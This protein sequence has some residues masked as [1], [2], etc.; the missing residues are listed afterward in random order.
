MTLS[1]DEKRLRAMF[2]RASADFIKANNPVGA[3]RVS[4]AVVKRDAPQALDGG[5]SA[6]GNGKAR[7]RVRITRFACRLLDE[8][9]LSGGVKPLLDSIKQA[10]LIE[11]DSP[12]C[13]ELC[14]RQEKVTNKVHERTEVEIEWDE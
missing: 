14:V 13:I 6:E 12:E 1:L 7:A 8:D 3:A 10:G 4:N 9:N 2:P 5:V 11:D